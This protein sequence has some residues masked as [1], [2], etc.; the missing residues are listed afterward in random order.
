MKHYIHWI[1]FILA[2][3][4]FLFEFVAR[5]EPGL[6]SQQISTYFQLSNAGFGTL[7]SLFFWIYAPMQLAVGVL[8]DRYGARHLLPAAILT[9]SVGVLIFSQSPNAIAAGLGR[10]CIGLGA[11]FAFVGALYVVNHQFKSSQFAILSGAVNAIGMVGTAVGAVALTAMID[12]AGWKSV[13]LYT[14][15]FGFILFI[16]SLIFLKD[17]SREKTNNPNVFASLHEVI[18]DPRIW[19]ISVIGALYYMPVNIF[20]GLWGKSELT[21]DHALSSVNAEIAVSMIFCGMAIGS[22]LAGIL[23]DKFGHRKYFI[24]GGALL[25]GVV[26]SIALYLPINSV[27]PLALL[28]FIAGILGGGQM[29]TFA[30]AKEYK[31]KSMSGTVIAFVNMLGIAGALIFQPLVGT[32]VDMEQGHFGLALLTI[33]VC[34]LLAGVLALTL[35]ENRHEDHTEASP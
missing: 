22:I 15:V 28:I 14:S 34:L 1:A 12:L 23:S 20:G 6:A 30:M 33:P 18:K 8:L 27:L 4:F 9:C 2:S 7:V 16:L 25:M 35:K 17:G 31:P 3:L 11:S 5:I 10:L 13:F 24:A 19:I 26:F 21:T 32:I 29:L